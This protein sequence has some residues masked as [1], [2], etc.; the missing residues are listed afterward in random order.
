MG[1][2]LKKGKV[3]IMLSGRYAGKKAIVVKTF[4][5]GTSTRKFPHALVAGVARYPRKVTKSMSKAKLQK[6][7]KIKPFIKAVN[8]THLMPT[9]YQCDLELQN[10]VTLENMGA[11]KKEKM[12]KTVKGLFEARYNNQDEAKSDKAFTGTQFF[13]DKLR[14]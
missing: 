3:V 14:F 8:F 11:D 2:I 9:R 6:K 5:D 7:L 13:F 10:T 1:K 12:A 4:D